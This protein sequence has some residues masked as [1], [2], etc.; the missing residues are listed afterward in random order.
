MVIVSLVQDKQRLQITDGRNLYATF[1][2]L[3]IVRSA[4]WNDNFRKTEL[5][6]FIYAL[7]EKRNGAYDTRKGNLSDE[8]GLSERRTFA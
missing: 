8:Y 4:L 1:P 5:S 3:S 6:R 7:S 2:R